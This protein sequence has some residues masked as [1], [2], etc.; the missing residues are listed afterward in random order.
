MNAGIGIRSRQRREEG[1]RTVAGKLFSFL[2]VFAM[3][4]C[5]VP[6]PWTDETPDPPGFEY[7]P[8]RILPSF[9][10]ESQGGNDWAWRIEVDDEIWRVDLRKQGP[11]KFTGSIRRMAKPGMPVLA[12]IPLSSRSVSRACA[13]V[14]DPPHLDGWKHPDGAVLIRLSAAALSEGS[15]GT[16]RFRNGK[17]DSCL[18]K[19][20]VSGAS[21]SSEQWQQEVLKW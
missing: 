8:D 17:P 3:T 10:E 4:A 21:G 7:Q 2:A 14:F 18:L 1:A 13:A 19:R 16:W 15:S 5:T 11:G 20:G 6:P 9:R 12:E